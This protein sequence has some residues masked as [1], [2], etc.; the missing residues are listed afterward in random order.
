[1]SLTSGEILNKGIK[2]DQITK[3]EVL[4]IIADPKNWDKD[5]SDVDKGC[6]WVWNG[7]VICPL[8]LK[9]ICAEDV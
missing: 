5:Y 3:D 9:N 8:D 4:D 6:R 1:M 7:P 2:G